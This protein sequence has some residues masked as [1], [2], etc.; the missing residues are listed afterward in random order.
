MNVTQ[1]IAKNM[2][3]LALT[4]VI[5]NIFSLFL[6]I[7]VTRILGPT[8]YGEYA[9]AIAFVSLFLI[10]SDL[11]ISAIVVRDVARDKSLVNKY[12]HN[13]LSIKIILA[14]ILAMLGAIIA[15]LLPEYHD[16]RFYIYIAAVASI[17]NLVAG[18]FNAGFQAFEKMEYSLYSN[19]VSSILYFVLGLGFVLH[20]YGVMGLIAARL[21]SNFG[22]LIINIAL[23]SKYI[24]KIGIEADLLF[25]KKLI[26]DGMPF[27]L[28]GVFVTI[29]GYTDILM[30]SIM[31][32]TEV[33][34]WYSA[35]Y[36]LVMAL[37]MIP[38]AYTAAV[39]PV[40]SKLSA[41]YRDTMRYAYEKS[42]KHLFI[43]A[44]PIGVG[45]TILAD[46]IIYTIYGSGFTNSIVVMKILIWTV[47]FN[48]M[49]MLFGTILNSSNK[50]RV[51]TFCIGISTFFNV[52]LNFLL[53]PGL[54]L[55]GASIASV[56]SGGVSLILLFYYVSKYLYKLKIFDIIMK[57]IFASIVMALS[58]IYINLDNLFLSVIEGAVVYFICL[59]IIKG[60]TE[61]DLRLIKSIVRVSKN[62]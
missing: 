9:T 3:A 18:V 23:S 43:I 4:L 16:I 42:F 20:G 15:T 60:F 36:Q 56:V 58:I 14:L 38:I 49:T 54:S 10:I 19:L 52:G 33:V 25:W 27:A 55:V 2:G 47:I 46:R 35:P 21:I 62:E 12:I 22:L 26:L 7:Y 17:F 48:F 28:L 44:F 31:K 30:L 32:S 6:V 37:S 45:T 24:T 51:A 41:S 61:D 8:G 13:F 1:R 39:F 40:F 11:G 29:Y 5:P 53:I 57:V 50:E 59:Y 34:G